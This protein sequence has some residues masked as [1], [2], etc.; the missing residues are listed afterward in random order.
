MQVTH[1]P[2][3]SGFELVLLILREREEAA[4]EQ[5]PHLAED[6][7]FRRREILRRAGSVAKEHELP[8]LFALGPQH[9]AAVRRIG[10]DFP[11]QRGD[12]AS[13]R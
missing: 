12:D 5:P 13:A 8:T 3:E 10:T 1:E 4:I 9:A 7:H 6:L 2:E 11:R